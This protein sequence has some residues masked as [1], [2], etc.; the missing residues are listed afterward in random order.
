MSLVLDHLRCH[1]FQRT[2][3]CISLLRVV[4]LNTPSEITDFDNVTVLDKYIFW[5]NISMDK[6]L[7]MHVIYS[8]TNLDKKV[9][10]CILAEIL[11]LSDQV[12]KVSFGC[13][14]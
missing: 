11:F 10:C 7:L 13:I 14:F 12:K 8:G 4:G 9:K 6:S 1:V 2:T 5:L 3:K